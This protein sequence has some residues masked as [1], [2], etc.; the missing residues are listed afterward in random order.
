LTPLYH[1]SSDVEELPLGNTFKLL[2]FSGKSPVNLGADDILSRHL[3]IYP[4]D[5]LLCQLPRIPQKDRSKVQLSLEEITARTNALVFFP[6]ANLFRQIRL[7]KP[8][9]LFA[10]ET[11]VLLKPALGTDFWE[12][13]V[14]QKASLMNIDFSTLPHESEGYDLSAAEAPFFVVFSAALS[15]LFDSLNNPECA[16]PQLEMALELFGRNDGL[17]NEV[18]YSLTALESL[19][20]GEST[21]ELA[22]RLS[23][24]VATLLGTDDESRKRVFKDMKEFY[25]L[26]SRIVHGSGFRLKPKHHARLQQ[27]PVLREYLRR[28]LLS[29]MALFMEGIS[30]SKLEELLDDVVLDDTARRKVQGSAEKYINLA[31]APSGQVS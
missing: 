17:D 28:I 31:F 4:P 19:L 26:R 1:F 10:G 5:Y 21:S 2:K 15:P 18:L 24:R 27:V 30:G 9:R 6:A 22:Y 23:L 3:Q 29:M 8:G 25:D 14:G 7:F 12:T 20:T 11:F 13:Q 16:F